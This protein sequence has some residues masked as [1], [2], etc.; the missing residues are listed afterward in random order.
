MLAGDFDRCACDGAAH[1]LVIV[2]SVSQWVRDHCYPSIEYHH[3][4]GRDRLTVDGKDDRV[5][6]HV[7]CIAKKCLAQGAIEAQRFSDGDIWV[8]WFKS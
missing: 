6:V 5:G 8:I 3:K 2:A 7:A 1:I 4:L